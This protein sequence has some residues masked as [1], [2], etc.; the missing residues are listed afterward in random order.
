MHPKH[1]DISARLLDIALDLFSRRGYEG[2][3]VQEIVAAAG[4][5][6]PT[7][8]HYFGS[9]IGVL[10]ALLDRNSLTETAGRNS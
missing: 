8:Y 7:L 1:P 3:G 10:K 2:T 4:V 6:K 9:K 5:T